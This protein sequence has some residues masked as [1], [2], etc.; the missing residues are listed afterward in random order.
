M[1]FFYS[2]GACPLAPHV[3]L[4]ETGAA[5]EPVCV[6]L[7]KGEQFTEAFAAINPRQRVPALQLDDGQVLTECHAIMSY[8]A[9]AYPEKR[10]LPTGA[11][12]RARAHE[13]MNWLSST[14][15]VTFATF[16]RSERYLGEGQ[17]PAPMKAA[18][19]QRY[20]ALMR[21]I[22]GKLPADG[23]VLGDYSVVDPYLMLFLRW[24]VRMDHDPAAYPNYLAHAR[25]VQDRPA[26]QR[27]LE[28]QGLEGL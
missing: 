26:T 28:I 25:R 2:P 19:R 20:D 11:L 9:D 3:V 21:E 23:F 14:V 7:A 10:L 8:L 24:A 16:F 4:E 15:H 22:D 13:W 5:Y 6:T 17:D 1:R 27:A 12:P 18:A